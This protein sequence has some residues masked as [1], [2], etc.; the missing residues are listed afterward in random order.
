[1][2]ADQTVLEVAEEAG[3]PIEYACRQGYCGICKV[4]LLS[5]EV[6]MNVKDGLSL[7]DQSSNMILACQAKAVGDIAVDA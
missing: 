4:K 1:M 3:I 6:S 2:K 5:G 7:L